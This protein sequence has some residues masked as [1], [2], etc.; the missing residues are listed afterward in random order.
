MNL[1]PG[2]YL[3]RKKDGTEYYRS[4]ITYRNKHISL[5]SYASMEDA[6]LAYLCAKKILD[7]ADIAL[8]DLL[9]S[10]AD[11][12]HLNFEK[13]IS[14]V[15]FRDHNLYFA[16]PIY[17]R[18]NFFEYYLSDEICLKFDIDD[19]FYYSS[20][21]IL[22]RNSHL[23]VA[24]YGSQISIITRYG[25]KPYSVLDRDYIHLNHDPYDYRRINLE[26]INRYNGVHRVDYKGGYRYKAIIHIKGNYLIGIY[27]SE[28]QAA[29]AYNKAID[30]LH[31]KGV[32]KNFTPN[33][34]DGLS[35]AIYATIYSEIPI[36]SK[37]LQYNPLS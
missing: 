31:K 27:D 2:V 33:F 4:N 1:L 10:P 17:L 19:L 9:K 12:A 21:K 11:Y 29:I 22:M 37:I 8:E 25:L 13:Q 18:K 15:N 7:S 16:N 36:S 26:I 6:N 5:G 34:L 30:I 20:H 35:P 32:K 23:C 28:D 24:D 3:A 14:L